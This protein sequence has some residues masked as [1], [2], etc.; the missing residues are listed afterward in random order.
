[1]VFV[2]DFYL[3]APQSTN[4]IAP[5][6]PH[7]SR[8][9]LPPP[10]LFAQTSRLSLPPLPNHFAWKQSP[11]S[12]VQQRM[13]TLNIRQRSWVQARGLIPL[14]ED[15]LFIPS[16]N[17]RIVKAFHPHEQGI[18][19]NNCTLKPKLPNE[20]VVT[21]RSPTQSP[22]LNRQIVKAFHSL[23]QESRKPIATL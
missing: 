3:S 2:G 9:N 1:M 10:F 16:T 6:N 22:L 7:S 14:Y 13:F 12:L 23:R 11:C 19:K 17:N 20:I 18:W 4:S 5:T 8:H 15:S 21:S